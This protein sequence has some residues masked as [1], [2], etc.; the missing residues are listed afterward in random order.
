[1]RTID[2]DAAIEQ[3]LAYLENPDLHRA[4][5]DAAL[6]HVEKCP[7]CQNRIRHLVRALTADEEDSLTCEECQDL[8]PEYLEAEARGE[9][10][11]AQ[12][13]PVAYHLE[14]C[15]H[16]SAERASL[17][18]LLELAHGERGEEPPRY[19]VPD[20][21]FL[22][23][24]QG[25]PR[26]PAGA[27]WHL[28]ELGRLI[29]EFSSELLRAFQVPAYQPAYAAAG[30]KSKKPPRTLCQL[31]LKEAVQDLEVTITAEEMRADPT[32][33]TVTVEVNIPSRGG[34]PHLAGTEVMLKRGDLGLDTQTTDAYGEAVF[35]GIATK[36]LSHLVFEIMPHP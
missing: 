30:I 21:S 20:L 8:L 6:S 35:E 10:H 16:C 27:P 24:E 13:R 9:A 15:P 12:W 29:V 31:S 14:T 34:W 17:S 18:E 2:C 19:P 26:Q 1:M 3:L 4:Q 33:C 22:R 36:D 23:R 7:H 32:R 5:A 28:D 25:K 11:K